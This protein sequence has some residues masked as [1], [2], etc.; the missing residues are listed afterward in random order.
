MR[1][2]PPKS[3][4]QRR[5]E[6]GST[7]SHRPM[8]EPLLVAGRPDLERF[9]DPPEGLPRDA[10]EFWRESIEK[11]V[12]VGVIDLVDTPALEILATA[13]ARI[14][15]ARRV[16][17]EEGHF[18]IGSGGQIKEH[19]ALKIEQN[20]MAMFERYMNH[21]ALSPVA[22]TRLGMAELSRKAMAAEL[23]RELGPDEGQQAP[24]PAD[25]EG[26]AFEEDLDGDI[27]LPGT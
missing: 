25:V 20:Y 17:A 21:F 5:L 4:E 19:P 12:E 3:V 13:Y 8:P 11:L 9:R 14:R 18:G 16:I 24:R 26:E 7:V 22:R 23:D 2:R 15:Q 1:G 10:Q 6:G 27:G